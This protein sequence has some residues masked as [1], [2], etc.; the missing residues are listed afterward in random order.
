MISSIETNFINVKTLNAIGTLAKNA[1][2]IMEFLH[3][4][5]QVFNGLAGILSELCHK[6][7]EF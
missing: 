5:A 1:D 6:S 4:H 2:F 7:A 3:N